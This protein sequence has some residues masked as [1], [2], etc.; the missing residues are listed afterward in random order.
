MYFINLFIVQMKPENNLPE[1]ISACF[2]QTFISN[3][4]I[5]SILEL[6]R[7]FSPVLVVSLDI[8]LFY[9]VSTVLTMVLFLNITEDVPLV[10]GSID[11][12]IQN[13]KN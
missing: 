8:I 2:G 7:H 6:L 12:N 13:N 11:F 5:V 10:L 9:S 3:P 4:A 1:A